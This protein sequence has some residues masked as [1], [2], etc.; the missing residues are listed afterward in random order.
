MIFSYDGLGERGKQTQFLGQTASPPF[1]VNRKSGEAGRKKTRV[2]RTRQFLFAIAF[3]FKPLIK[4]YIERYGR[5]FIV[6][7]CGPF[8]RVEVKQGPIYVKG[9]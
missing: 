7:N 6:V 2:R 5:T 4:F 8:L 3:Y 9:R 1:N